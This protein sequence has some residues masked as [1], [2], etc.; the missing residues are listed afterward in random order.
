MDP[1]QEVERRLQN[2]D[3][4]EKSNIELFKAFDQLWR[5]RGSAGNEDVTQ[6]RNQL[7][8]QN[9]NLIDQLNKQTSRLEASNDEVRSLSR[10]VRDRD[11]KIEKLSAKIEYL[12]SEISEKNK[13][14]EIIN[15]EYLVSQISQ[16][17]MKEEV[18]KLK[19]E[20]ESLIRRWLEKVKLDADSMNSLNEKSISP[21]S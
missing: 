5:M 18:D 3:A 1:W 2:R 6:H 4:I 19:T 7:L 17:A 21:P 8:A 11:N 13:S 15:D 10:Q 20:N 14:I 16:N 9:E 12:R